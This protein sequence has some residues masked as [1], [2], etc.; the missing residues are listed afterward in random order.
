MPSHNYQPRAWGQKTIE[1]LALPSGDAC[2]VR[3]VSPADLL[4]GSLQGVN[5]LGNI[6]TEK[7]KRATT[8]A[9]G[10][11]SPGRGLSPLDH[12]EIDQALESLTKEPMAIV[13]VIDQIVLAAVVEPT[14]Q[15]CPENY[16][17][18]VDG[19][20]YVDSIPFEDKMAIFDWAMKGMNQLKEFREAADTPV[21]TVESVEGVPLPPQ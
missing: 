16:T 5:V 8:P 2:L 9:T 4:A 13:S 10:P 18:R 3:R 1:E 19:V 6:I 12:A 20:I 17:E 14:V 21:G 7:I 15:P 11:G